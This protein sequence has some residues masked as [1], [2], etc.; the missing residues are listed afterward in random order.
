MKNCEQS[1]Y[2]CLKY[3]HGVLNITFFCS[4]KRKLFLHTRENEYINTIYSTFRDRPFTIFFQVLIY[5]R[6]SQDT[7]PL[8]TVFAIPCF[9]CEMASST[10]TNL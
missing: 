3:R 4:A 2:N 10:A 5:I 1:S 8:I 6:N 7:L 9:S